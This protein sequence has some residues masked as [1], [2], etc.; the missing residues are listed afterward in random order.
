MRLKAV[1]AAVAVAFTGLALMAPAPVKALDLN[2][3]LDRT[4]PPAGFGEVRAI[5]HWAYYP[6]YQHVYHVNHVTDPYAYHYEPRGYYPYYG[7]NYWRRPRVVDRP[8]V[9]PQYYSSWGY[10]RQWEHRAWHGRHHG[11]HWPWHW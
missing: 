3:N 4:R 1:L 10:P 9:L 6:R 8:H 11:R 2:L 5:N 7:S